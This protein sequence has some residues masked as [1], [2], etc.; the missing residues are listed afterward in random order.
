MLHTKLTVAPNSTTAAATDSNHSRAV[1]EL[2][3]VGCP[4]CAAVGDGVGGG[5][6]VGEGGVLP[7]AWRPAKTKQG[8]NSVLFYCSSTAVLFY[9]S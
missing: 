8:K 9:S 1:P 4:L 5:A 2:L 6:A 3:W 7:A